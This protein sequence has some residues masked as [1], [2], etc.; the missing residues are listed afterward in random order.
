MSATITSTQ[1][2]SLRK[3]NV[4]PDAHVHTRPHTYHTVKIGDCRIFVRIG[5]QQQLSIGMKG[6]VC[7]NALPV[8][9]KEVSYSLHFWLRFWERTTVRIVTRVCRGSFICKSEK[10]MGCGLRQGRNQKQK[11]ALLSWAFS[12]F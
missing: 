2:H 11:Q 10:K 1:N 3:K 4:R 5:I 12:Y 6:Q 9:S 8:F 7:P